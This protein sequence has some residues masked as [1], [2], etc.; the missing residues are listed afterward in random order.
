[1]LSGKL[2][3]TFDYFIKRNKNMLVPVTYPSL[4]GAIP[5]FSNSGE[6]KTW[7]FETAIGW[8]D[9]VGSVRYSV[10]FILS[11]AQN[12]VTHYGGTDTYI[13]GLNSLN[14]W[15]YQS[16]REGDPLDSYYGYTFDGV[17]RDQKELDAYKQLGGVPS[18]IKIGD[19]KFKDLNGDGKISLYGD[20]PGQQGDVTNLGSLTPRYN[21][22]LNLNFYYKNFDL[23]IFLQGVAERT[24]FRDGDYAMPWSAWWRQPPVF[25]FGQTWN[26]D[27][28]NAKYP[29]L[30]F[31]NINYWNYQ[32]STLQKINA[33]YVRLK[34]LQVGY[35]LP[36]NLVNKISMSRARIYFSGQDIWELHGVKGGWDP[37]ASTSG[38][39]YPFQRMYSAGIEITFK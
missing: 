26:G 18:D 38:F 3:F 7:G 34:N 36:V 4:L 24:I 19:A 10:K 8:N 30:S 23:G 1:M 33:A 11:D 16:P 9:K 31:G 17:I 21:F 27:R 2:N 13:L 28:P 12:E 20:K 37:E 25:Y 39:N 29:E 35:T 22:G 14:Q 6:L 32:P 15:P 5:P